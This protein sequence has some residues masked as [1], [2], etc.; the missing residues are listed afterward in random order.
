MP[1]FFLT[2]RA[3]P[4]EPQVF[5]DF[6][7]LLFKDIQKKSRYAW[8]IEWDQTPQ[9]HIHVLLCDVR[10]IDKI[11]TMLNNKPYKQFKEYLKDKNTVW[12]PDDDNKGFFN[13]ITCDDKDITKSTLYYLGYVNKHNNPRRDQKLFT[14]QEIT[15]AV[16]EYH[17]VQ[18]ISHKEI[19][20]NDIKLITTKNI[21]SNIISFVENEDNDTD[22]DDRYLKYKTIKKGFGYAQVSDKIEEKVFQELRI[23]KNKEWKNDK[24]ISNLKSIPS[25]E[26][27]D[28]Y[29]YQE[30]QER[31]T[32]DIEY[33]INLIKNNNI[34]LS[35]ME[36]SK[37]KNISFNYKINQ[38]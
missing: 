8:S 14:Q 19:K 31:T 12:L 9:R 7:I 29:K 3:H 22:Y 36:L 5:E 28:I 15:D 35:N 18:R 17:S 1:N 25:Q 11:K 38:N 34:S 21:Y 10:D 26:T 37:I 4:S 16:K 27:V 23:F 13:C 32:N 2:F 30:L 6:L 20:N 33:L 24:E